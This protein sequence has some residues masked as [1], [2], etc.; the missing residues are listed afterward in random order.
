MG[1][2][3]IKNLVDNFDFKVLSG[4]SKIN[5]KIH[6]YGLNRAGLELTGFYGKKGTGHKRAILMSSK[7]NQYMSQFDDA[8]KRAKYNDLLTSGAP[9]V[10][11]TQKFD[12]QILVDVANELDFPLL[13]IDYPSTSEL[14]QRILD[15]YDDYF[16]PSEEVHGSLVNIFGKGIMVIG[17]SGIGKSEITLELVKHNH[18]FVGDDR[19][20]LT[21]KGNK[22]F[23]KSH[24]I[25][26][27]LVEVRGIGIIDVSKTNG[28]QII[29]DETPLDMVIELFKFG[30][31]G[32]DD[33]E[34][35][36]REPALKNVLG[37]N[38]P[39]MKIP[40]SS[41]R[42]ISNIIESAVAQLKI[43]Q[44]DDKV[45]IIEL[46]NQ[47]IMKTNEEAND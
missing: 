15:L 42:N 7:E 25:L 11:V 40:V 43:N 3:A 38:V 10:I 47:R 21:N 46:M 23:G 19:I 36:G 22:I 29:M 33:S 17:Q 35:I 26:K 6:V 24:P 8:T 5:N 32:V 4:E 44:S 37:V 27:N 28:Y 30:T 16:A 1:K 45:D 9:L 12:D 39:H 13:S 18:L 20:I 34:R 14:T 2:I 41:G 31:N